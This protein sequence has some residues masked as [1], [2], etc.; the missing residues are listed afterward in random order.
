MNPRHRWLTVLLVLIV[1]ALIIAGCERPL[2][3][4]EDIPELQATVGAIAEDAGE[5]AG[6]VIAGAGDVAATT[7]AEVGGEET[8]TVESPPEATPPGESP[9][10]EA[11]GTPADAGQGEEEEQEQPVTAAATAEATSVEAEASATIAATEA[12][13]IAPTAESTPEATAAA[14][15]AATPSDT[16]VITSTATVAAT[17]LPTVAAT[18][19]ATVA[20]TPAATIAATVAATIAPTAAATPGG[21][22]ATHTVQPGETLYEI[23]LLYGI[24]WVTLAQ[25]N[26]LANADRIDAGQMLRIP[27]GGD[28]TATPTVVATPSAETTYV[29]QP[30]DNLF[31]I[32]QVYN[33]NWRLIAEANGI[34][35]P[36]Q[37]YAGQVLK[38]PVNAPG[39]LPQFTHVVQ[40]GETLFLISLRYGV[41]WPAIAE[42]NGITSPYVIYTG[43]TLVIPGG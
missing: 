42:A 38:I 30:G 16:T 1:G 12:A 11:T 40:P 27:G 43:Q 6:T 36:N 24:S 2:Q 17:P 26:N 18:P 22:P 35:N 5:A 19:A 29:V 41:A 33:I 39:P 20:A 3:R 28:S 34:V 13:T 25:F 32:G 7:A 8:A 4:D 31:R 21:T 14:T 9:R 10:E 23:G 15:I 37:I